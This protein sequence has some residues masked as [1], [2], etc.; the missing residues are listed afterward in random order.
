LIAT[1]NQIAIS[2]TGNPGMASGGMGDVLAGVIASLVAQG[3][4][5]EDAA[6]QGAYAHGIAADNAVKQDGERGLLASDLLS[7][8]R[9][10]INAH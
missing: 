2:N 5:L 10:W 1:D 8:L 4:S 7:Y 9:H 6:K 3:M